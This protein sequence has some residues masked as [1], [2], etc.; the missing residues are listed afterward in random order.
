MKIDVERSV[1]EQIIENSPAFI[2]VL[3]APD[4]VFITVNHKYL[5]LIGHRDVIGKPL[6][7]AL[8]EIKGQGF[9]DIIRAVIKTRETFTGYELP[10]QLQRRANEPSELRYV[11]VVYQRLLGTNGELDRVFAHGIDVTDKVLA[12]KK[13]EASELELR[14]FA[15]AMPHMAFIADETGSITFFNR[16]WY[17]YVQ[18]TND[19]EGWGWKD[20]NIHH[21]DDL[22][23][24]IDRWLHSLKTGEVY[25]IQYR[26]RRHDGVYRWH[27][28]KA[29]PFKRP[30][31]SIERWIGT[32]TDIHDYQT[33]LE[34]LSE[35][36]EK[37]RTIADAMPQMVWS[38]LPNGYHDY[39]NDRWYEFTGM[40]PGS[41]EGEAWNDLFHPDDRQMSWEVWKQS[42]ETGEPYKIEY[43]LRFRDGTYRWTLGRALPLRK[44]DGTI[45]PVDGNL[46]RHPRH[47]AQ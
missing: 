47:Q 36:E 38:T 10:V 2:A 34:L 5:E 21:P 17:E 15:D 19:T 23:R 32:N 11:D 18:G 20:Q 40:P 35:S 14:E 8:P 12:R 39:F 16:R 22:Q 46:H 13:V 26:L 30:D 3:T 25:E 27:F 28:G 41:T 24:T 44:E 4:L 6:S 9:E 33:A 37:F 7:E 43:R 31:G 29:I 42:L 45:V 1:L